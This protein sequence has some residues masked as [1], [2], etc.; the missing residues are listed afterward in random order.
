VN[1]KVAQALLAKRGCVVTTAADGQAAVETYSRESFDV[2]LM[3]VQMPNVDGFTATRMIRD[4]EAQ[5][6]RRTPIIAMTAHAMQGDREQCLAVGMDGYVTKPIEPDELYAAIDQAAPKR[7]DA[8][9]RP[10]RPA[11]GDAG[12]VV[13]W[14]AALR[15]LYGDEALLRSMA[16]TFLLEAEPLFAEAR[17]ALEAA[18]GARLRRAGHTIKGSFGYF[19]ARGGFDA[20]VRLE[21]AAKKEDW[22]AAG[23]A[24]EELVRIWSETEGELIEF[25]RQRDLI[26][27]PQS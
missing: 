3:D 8:D 5:G 13:D 17:A 4:R 9:R 11:R 21:A 2:I 27:A 16:E 25:C 18:D 12:G 22:A 15:R 6:L 14:S 23:E 20:G 24:L 26:E 7:R 10:L 1:Q 19:A